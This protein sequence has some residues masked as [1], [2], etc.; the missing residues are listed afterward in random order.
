[1]AYLH[2]GVYIEEIPSGSRPIE[3]VATSVAA[4]VGKATK[5]PVGEARLIQ[6]FDDYNNEY[7]DIASEK[8]AMGLAVQAFYLNGGKTAYIC[9]LAGAG[10]AAASSAVKGQGTLQ[11]TTGAQTAKSVLR[12]SASSKGDWGN[13]LY[14]RIVKADQD[15]LNFDLEIGHMEKGQFISDESFAGLTMRAGDDNYALDRVNGN[16]SYVELSL[17]ES[18]DPADSA[19]EQYQ[20][21]SLSGGALDATD[22]TYYSA[23]ITGPV[24][25]TLNINSL[26]AKLITLT[27]SNFTT[28][29]LGTAHADDAAALAAEIQKA[30]RAL[31]TED[32][33]QGFSCVFSTDKFVLSSAEPSDEDEKSTASIEVSDG[34]LAA[35]LRM[36]S[37]QPAVLL[38]HGGSFNASY[39]DT[40]ITGQMTLTFE[41]D[42]HGS[43]TITLDTTNIDLSGDNKSD[44]ENIAAAIQNAVQAL[45]PAIAAYKDFKCEYL[46]DS[47][48][49]NRKFR[50]TSGNAS[51]R[52]SDLSVDAASLGGVLKLDTTSGAATTVGRSI[53]Q[54]TYRV[55]PLQTL[56]LNEQGVALLDGKENDATA[57]DFTD[58]Y[59]SV[60]RKVRDV[61]I[62]L[63]PGEYWASDGSGNAILSASLAHCQAV[64]SRVLIVD[65]PPSLELDQA[66]TVNGLALP[67]STYSV[68]YYPWVKVANPLYHAEKNP[69]ADKTIDVAPSSFA[70]GMWS[71]IDG[72][73][74]VWKA[75]AGMGTGLLGVADFK[76]KVEDGEQDQLNP[77]G[78]NCFRNMPGGGRVIWGARTLATKA[79]PEWRYVPVRRTAIMIEQSIFNGIQWAVFEP[80]DHRLWSS[81]RANIGN[82]MNG[83][84]RAG[85]FQG[86]KASDAYFVRCGLGDTMTQGDIDAGQV[87]VIVGFAPL[88]PAEFVI[89]R[90][91]QKVNLQ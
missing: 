82:F 69:T 91:Q 51:A 42:K 44:G 78:V 79:D 36:D 54:G 89:V 5:G 12:I 45:N 14:Y 23:A 32:A 84:F 13:K 7:G 35:L 18:A 80:N 38:G 86:E 72:K 27:P 8:D 71:R 30:V 70:A 88:K 3:G 11:G 61:S 26:G 25:L 29:L 56:G 37:K 2:P 43:E 64:K 83:L 55:I 47:T 31:S 1:M 50:M 15:S 40:N 68:L 6:S 24:T 48:L 39:F 9:R 20:A 17:E 52:T 76:Y 58:F 21:A 53:S 60:L 63:N 66:A 62:L 65:P 57:N 10:S 59:D 90:I 81:L 67:S 75:P 73:R 4:F 77:L 16:S 22:N 19:E 34:T 87:I 28:P 85:A 33:Y 74:G 41:I 46:Y 49:A